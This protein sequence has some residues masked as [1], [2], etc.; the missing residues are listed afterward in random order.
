MSMFKNIYF[1]RARLFPAILTSIPLLIFVNKIL[2]IEYSDALRNVFDVLPLITHV[3]LSGALIFLC[4]QVNRLLA[5]EIFQRLYFKEEQKMPT[6]THLLW[7]STYYDHIVKKK[8]HSKMNEKFGIQLLSPYE[9]QQDELR[10]RNLI[11]AC[12]GQ[13]RIA[14]KG[15]EML[16]QHNIEYGFW[17]NLIGGSVLAVLFSIAIFIYGNS[18]GLTDLRSLGILLFI[19]YFLPLMLSK[20]IINKYGKYYSKILYEQFLS[21]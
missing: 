21:L 5:K 7:K 20:M 9:E 10:A 3:G 18:K 11:V 17:R 8:I 6:T 15:N 4:V 19:V 1:Y 13:V 2:A 14:L 12:V 16:L